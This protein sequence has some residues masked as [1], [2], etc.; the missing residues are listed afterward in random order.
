M[1][2]T[3]KP[4][5]D[6]EALRYKGTP[7]KPDI[8]IFVSHRIDLDSETI[9][10]PL[11]IPV[12]CGAVYD[13]RENVT[14]L[15]DDTGDNI[16]TRRMTFNEFTV[17]YWAWKNVKADY[18]GL[19]HYRRF[20]SFYGEDIP[21]GA[22][23][24]GL[25]DSMSPDTIQ[26]YGFLSEDNIQEQIAEQDIIVPYEYHMKHDMLPSSTCQTIK[27]QWLTYCS[28]YLKEEHFRLMLELIKKHAPEYYASALKFCKGKHFRGFNCFIMKQEYFFQLCEFIFP[29]LFD[30]DKQLDRAHFSTTQNRACGYLGEWLFSIFVYHMQKYSKAKINER[31]LIAFLN[32]DKSPKPKPVFTTDAVAIAM[33]LNDGNRPLAAVTLQSLLSHISPNTN[34]DIILLQRSFDADQWCNY[35]RKQ[36]NNSLLQLAKEYP[37]VSIRFYDPKNELGK[38]DI[39]K[40]RRNIPEEQFYIH[41]APWVLSSFERVIWLNDGILV[42]SDIAELNNIDLENYYAAA[43]KNP[44]FSA[45][46]NGYIPDALSEFGEKLKMHDLYNYVSIEVA[47]LNL[48]KIRNEFTYSQIE[49]YLLKQQCDCPSVDCFNHLFENNIYFLHQSWNC[50]ECCS[51]EYF[52]LSEFIPS[53]I[54]AELSESKQP[55]AYNL[56]GM[57]NGWVP[58][59]SQTAKRFW[60]YARM[61]DFYEEILTKMIVPFNGCVPMHYSNARKLADRIFPDGSYRRKIMKIILPKGSL[62]WNILK[63]IYYMVGGK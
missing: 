51:P 39:Q 53:D 10:N 16:S 21:Y 24:Q 38:L 36:Q 3:Y 15:G 8:K 17:M 48:S 49:E 30:F 63:K 41:I 44:I 12:R 62:R 19:C 42:N 54:S 37:N 22:L 34:Y 35:L 20:L 29:I 26:Q 28:A 4:V 47:V 56:S 43:V 25:A 33:P 58:Q 57:V 45:M 60:K 18:Y 1:E 2:K 13:K 6:V 40:M 31:Q 7:E 5:P 32:T 50:I 46:I 27:E 61:T 55:K 9:D 23:K 52:K 59:Q 14:M 11:Y